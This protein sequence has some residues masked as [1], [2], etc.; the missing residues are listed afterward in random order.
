MPEAQPSGSYTPLA[1]VRV[2]DL[3]RVLAGP[4][5]TMI[6]AD[7]GAEVVKIER[8]EVGDDARRVGPFLPSG[9]SGYFASVNRGK[10]SVILN[11][12]DKADRDTLL[13]LV[14][15]ADVLVENFRPGVM[16]KLGL[17][18]DVLQAANPRLIYAAVSGFGKAGLHGNRAAYDIIVQA[19]SGLMSVT[20]TDRDHP[21]RVGSSISDILSGMFTAIGILA[22]LR[23]RDRD[24]KGACLD[25]A[26]LD[27]TVA[28]MENAIMRY[29]VT[30]RAPEPL[31][32]RHPT[33][34]PFQAFH[35]SDGAIVV[36]A[37]NDAMW[38][39]LCEAVGKPELA[40]DPRLAAN[41]DRIENYAFLEEILAP[42]FRAA[43]SE[44]WL[45]RL[46][47]A[48]VPCAPVR[49]MTAVLNDE[50]L[51]AREMFHVMEDNKGG[52]FRTASTPFFINGRRPELS[53]HAPKL[54][55][56]TEA[57]VKEWLGADRALR[58]G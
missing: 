17:G 4:F 41:Q 56:H 26:M 36:A 53:S 42:I 14:R 31:G 39:K 21:V 52:T 33:I 30:G 38:V 43:S 1:G 49:D 46:M 18:S 8:P 40:D 22:A 51:K 6:L 58:T 2:L 10:K 7:L 15:H 54:G 44:E 23:G 16:E 5:C 29:A 34:T 28:V 19:M 47:N 3:T 48:G 35:T 9:L 25:M 50:H 57:V 12:K 20:G 37:G 13:E 55:E 32:T 11:L 45:M 27:C 24:R